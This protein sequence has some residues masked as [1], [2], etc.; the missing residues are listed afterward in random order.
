MVTVGYFTRLAEGRYLATELTSGAWSVSEQHISPMGGLITAEIER[1]A[2]P[3]GK[4]LGRLGMDILGVVMVGEFEVTVETV[5]PGRT[6]SLIEARVAQA[7]RT[8]VIARAW[9]LA[10]HD[11][12]PVAGGGVD[13]IPVPD[14]LPLWDMSTVWPGGYIGSIE[15]RRVADAEPGRAVAWVRSPID[16]ITGEPVSGLARWMA[17]IDTANGL[18][19]RESPEKWLFPNVDLTVHLHR[20]PVGDWVGFDTRVTFGATGLGLTSTVLHDV[21][22][23]VG[24]AEQVLTVRPRD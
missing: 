14:E 23:P 20:L 21:E 9:R 11:S 12:A 8:A 3:D 17:L 18:S 24:R 22:G 19:V 10:P 6:I 5:R 13:P 15:V 1:A 16:L 7:G 2:G 4:V